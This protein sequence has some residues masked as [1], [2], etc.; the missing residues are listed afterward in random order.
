MIFDKTN[1]IRNLCILYSSLS[2]SYFVTNFPREKSGRFNG[3][4]VETENNRG[5]E[6][7]DTSHS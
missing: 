6:I 3:D 1:Q 5:A 2:D 4:Q 7:L